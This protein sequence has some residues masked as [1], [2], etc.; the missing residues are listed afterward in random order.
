MKLRDILTEVFDRKVDS[1]V[2]VH[3]STKYQLESTITGRKIKVVFSKIPSESDGWDFEFYEQTKSGKWTTATTGSGGSL[4]V[5]AFVTQALR[6]FID[7]YH[8]ETVEFNAFDE[9]DP[10]RGRLYQKAIEKMK[11]DYDLEAG[12]TWKSNQH[13]FTLRR[14][15]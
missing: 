12:R 2:V 9:D 14:K 7:I 8:P 1:D 10:K 15:Q 5:F 3:S 6:E 13:T 11:L 4:E